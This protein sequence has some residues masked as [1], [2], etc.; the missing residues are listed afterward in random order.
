[1]HAFKFNRSQAGSGKVKGISVYPE[2]V[3]RR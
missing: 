3:Q 1:M 2:M